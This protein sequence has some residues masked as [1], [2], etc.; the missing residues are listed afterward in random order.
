[1]GLDPFF[2]FGAVEI[3]KADMQV[4]IGGI[5]LVRPALVEHHALGDRTL[6]SECVGLLARI[7]GKDQ[8]E[9]R[10]GRHAHEQ[11]EQG[12]IEALVEA[13]H[14][15]APRQS[16]RARS[17]QIFVITGAPIFAFGPGQPAAALSS[18]TRTLARKSS[19]SARSFTPASSTA[20]EPSS[21]ER[22]EAWVC[23]AASVTLS[24]AEATM[25]APRA[26]LATLSEIWPVAALCCSIDAA[27]AEV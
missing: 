5:E 13:T 19:T 18:A 7:E 17:R 15:P 9:E 4:V 8:H 21:M 10:G 24:S 26:A 27:T 12:V 20:W 3:N 2:A 6:A 1:M 11:H 16:L 25:P 14:D 23:V 22:A